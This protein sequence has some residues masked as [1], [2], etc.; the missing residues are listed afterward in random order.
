MFERY[1]EEATKT[2]RFARNEAADLGSSE[3]TP[4]H[5]LIGLVSDAGLVNGVMSGASAHEIRDEVKARLS[6]RPAEAAPDEMHLSKESKKALALARKEAQ[7]FSSRYVS[8]CHILLG[9]IQI[10]DSLAAQVLR[11]SGPSA[12]YVRDRMSTLSERA[13]EEHTHQ[14]K[15]DVAHATS[16]AKRDLD[17][18]WLIVFELAELDDDLG[19]LELVDDVIRNPAFDRNEAIQ[20]L[21]PVASVIARKIGNLDLE[22]R[23]CELEIACDPESLG[24]LY[25]LARCLKRQGK[26]EEAIKVARRTYQLGMTQGDELGRSYVEMIKKQFPDINWGT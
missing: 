24:A 15:A 6:R 21:V 9:L 26:S 4:E 11:R 5:I 8:N 13:K 16:R 20:K 22:K 14:T 12:D 23:Y 3:I 17:D 7:T 2:I 25:G 10:A 18:I 1:L 19:A